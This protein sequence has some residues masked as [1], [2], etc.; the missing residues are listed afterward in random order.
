VSPEA[1]RLARALRASLPRAAH[2]GTGNGQEPGWPAPPPGNPVSHAGPAGGEEP[3][4][5]STEELERRLLATVLSNRAEAVSVT[6]W[7]PAGAFTSAPLRDLY[8]LACQRLENGRAVDPLVIA[9]D[10]SQLPGRSP[11]DRERLVRLALRLSTDPAPPT[12]AALRRA[13]QADYV[14]S[15][16]VGPRWDTDA[17]RVRRLIAPAPGSPGQQRGEPEPVPAA[18]RAATVPVPA[19]GTGQL[20][21]PRQPLA[22]PSPAGHPEPAQARSG[23]PAPPQPLAAQ[24]LRRPAAPAVNGP[25]QRM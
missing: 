1:A 24:L 15:T 22:A 12:G 9:W 13:V 23:Q 25:V 21:T 5:G 17:E 2:P 11:Q 14:L 8:E 7:M 6:G 19:P 10:A 20:A 16:L 3:A 4:P 18:A